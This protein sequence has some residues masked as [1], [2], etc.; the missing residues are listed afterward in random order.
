[1][2]VTHNNPDMLPRNGRL[3]LGNWK[4]HGNASDN[5]TLLR[6]LLMCSEQVPTSVALGVCVP[7]PYLAQV[8][9]LLQ[10]SPIS[11]GAQDLSAHDKGAFTGEVSAKMLSDF[12]CTWVLV[13]HSERRQMHG[14]TN[15]LVAQKAQQAVV[16]GLIP[17]VCVGE[18][19]Q[20]HEDGLT[21]DVIRQ[22]LEP[23]L[24]LGGEQLSK[25][26]IAYEPI[27]AIGT[28]LTATPEEAQK[29][30][31]YIRSLL[32]ENGAEDV[33]ILYGGSVKADNAASLFA[34]PDINGALVGGASL[35]ASDF[36]AI[37]TIDA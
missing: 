16:H 24:A 15:E 34:M 28:G 9:D 29:V 13:G 1:M 21:L 14:E 31:Q 11:W 35:V 18:S 27:W 17:V 4:M 37:A 33:Y 22:Q 25:M 36:I 2:I 26:V 3:I 20:D 12:N 10:E 30:H 6:Q 5:N 32:A 8:N 7:F 23:V 19:F